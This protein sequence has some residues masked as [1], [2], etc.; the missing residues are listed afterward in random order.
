MWNKRLLIMAAFV[1]LVAS[2]QAQQDPT[3]PGEGYKGSKQQSPQTA[4]VVSAI[5]Y[6]PQRAWAMINNQMVYEGDKLSD[7]VT[8]VSIA[9]A[10][11]RLKVKKKNAWQSLT[12]NVNAPGTKIKVRHAD[13][14]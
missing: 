12:L 8:V 11:V 9:P 3:R 5:F 6:S 10:S 14:N 13:N 7:S 4:L 2:V 1:A